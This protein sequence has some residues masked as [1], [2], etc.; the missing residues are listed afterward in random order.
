MKKAERVLSIYRAT[1]PKAS[2]CVVKYAK[3]LLKLVLK[4]P[5]DEPSLWLTY[6]CGGVSLAWQVRC[7]RAAS[8]LTLPH[9]D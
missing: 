9:T 6:L 8:A 1:K 3:Y 4:D 7:A 2:F 5:L